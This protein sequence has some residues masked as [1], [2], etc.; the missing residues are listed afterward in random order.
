MGSSIINQA[1]WGSPHLW[2]PL[3]GIRRAIAVAQLR[4]TEWVAECS[5][6]R[7]WFK[8]SALGESMTPF[9]M[10]QFVPSAWWIYR[11]YTNKSK[12]GID[13]S[14][15]CFWTKV[16]IYKVFNV[17][18]LAMPP[19]EN[20]HIML[21]YIHSSGMVKTQ[22]G[23]ADFEWDTIACKFLNFSMLPSSSI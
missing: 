19:P 22:G 15:R 20:S 5:T 2:K 3:L 18:L 13:T 12:S 14:V 4:S 11:R 23:M 6:S 1:F 8:S 10:N 16:T 17:D 21:L 7:H 9:G